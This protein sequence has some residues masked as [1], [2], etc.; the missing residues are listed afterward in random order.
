MGSDGYIDLQV[1]GYAGTDFN[2]PSMD[3]E[4][5]H[6]AARRLRQD[7][8]AKILATVVTASPENMTTCLRNLVAARADDP[9]TAEVIAGFHVEGP[10]ISP[11]A[12]YR[13]AHP[14]ESV[15]MADR[16]FAAN[17]LE[18]GAGFIKLFTLAPESDPGGRVTRW[19]ADHGVQVAAGHTNASLDE[20]Q[21]C[22]DQ[23]LTL[24]THLGNGCP[25]QM[26]RHDNI[27]QR[28]LSLRRH[29]HYGLIADGVHLPPFV[30][31]NIIDLAGISRCFA[32]TDGISKWTIRW[33]FGRPTARILSDPPPPCAVARRFWLTSGSA[34]KRW[35]ASLSIIP[36]GSS[37]ALGEVTFQ[38]GR[39]LSGLP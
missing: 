36:P 24:F 7:G 30:L 32:V 16:D 35:I 26:H 22:I 38:G 34:G 13:G 1:N 2:D 23:G 4:Q 12:G 19:L 15:R 10:F 37:A 8:T 3:M 33:W 14:A 28:A 18:A 21:S 27:I 25:M 39:S 9:L 5:I 31:R 11:E 6:G 29:L 17:L 20:L